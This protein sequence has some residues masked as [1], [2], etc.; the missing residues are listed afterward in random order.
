MKPSLTPSLYCRTI[1]ANSS[2]VYTHTHIQQLLL[3]FERHRSSIT[4]YTQRISSRVG[5]RCNLCIN[6]SEHAKK[7]LTYP[8]P[9]R[10][11]RHIIY[12]V[13]KAHRS[14]IYTKTEATD[15]LSAKANLLA[16]YANT[17]VNYAISTKANPSTTYTN[18]KANDALSAN[19]N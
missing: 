6:D 17:E 5:G 14:T 13:P 2:D 3:N 9:T 11:Q 8:P 1:T 15:A 7:R 12:K 19:A 4:R 18:T 10:R 16:A